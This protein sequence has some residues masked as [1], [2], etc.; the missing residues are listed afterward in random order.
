MNS[1]GGP[2]DVTFT[3]YNPT[4]IGTLSQYLP[5][6]VERELN[7]IS[8][9]I[10]Q[11]GNAVRA[12][13]LAVPPDW[14]AT[15][16]TIQTQIAAI[17]AKQITGTA[18]ID[19]VGLDTFVLTGLP[20]YPNISCVIANISGLSSTL[21]IPNAGLF[22]GHEVVV[23]LANS[24]AG[25]NLVVTTVGGTVPINAGLAAAGTDYTLPQTP[26]ATI[27]GATFQWSTAAAC[28]QV[29]ATAIR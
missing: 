9:S 19:C 28:W 10:N 21:Q 1:V 23:K 4:S 5:D 29:I 26:S 17:A 7:K 22:D 6:A 25:G 16:K 27:Y 11:I 14:R 18:V 13:G 24:D 2:V 20:G 8:N 12:V 3:R 15:V